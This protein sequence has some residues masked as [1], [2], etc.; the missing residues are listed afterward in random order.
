[1]KLVLI[2]ALANNYVIGNQGEI[3]WYIP[4]DLR[5]FKDLT[6]N[7]PVIMGRNTYDSILKRLHKP[8]PKRTNIVISTTLSPQSDMLIARDLDEAL[9]IAETR[10][11]DVSFVIGGER[12]Y[13]EAI[14]R[15]HR[16]ELTELYSSYGGDAY[17]PRFDLCE[18]REFAREKRLTYDFVTYVRT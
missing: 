15:A 18:W 7:H 11:L 5:R 13:R 14:D 12:V 10:D 3:P 6:L 9:T 8:L 17:F 16:L 4:E 1:M 2:A